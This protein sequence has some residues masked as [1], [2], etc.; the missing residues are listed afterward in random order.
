MEIVRD[1]AGLE[2][3]RAISTVLATVLFTDLVEST[4]SRLSSGTAAGGSY[5]SHITR[6][7]GKRSP[8]G[9]AAS[10]TRPATASSPASQGQRSPSIAPT[11]S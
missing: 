8:A 11:R 3:P 6:R 4:Q 7:C 5:C 2:R 10:T 9:A 1:L